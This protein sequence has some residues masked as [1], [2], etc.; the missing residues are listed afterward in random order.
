MDSLENERQSQLIRCS[1]WDILRLTLDPPLSAV[2]QW[3]RASLST[4]LNG[5]SLPR[6]IGIIGSLNPR[7][8]LGDTGRVRLVNLIYMKLVLNRLPHLSDRVNAPPSIIPPY[9]VGRLEIDKLAV[10]GYP[11]LLLWGRSV[12]VTYNAPRTPHV[13]KW[14]RV[15][16]SRELRCP[17]S[18]R[19]SRRST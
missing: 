18:P 13:M 2:G 16:R 4:P 6:M 1:R 8:P 14:R 5:D 10:V 19:C 12:N 3:T 7:C 15:S 11:P 17:G 9:T